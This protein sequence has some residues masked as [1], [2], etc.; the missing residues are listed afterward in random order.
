[1]D[2]KINIESPDQIEAF[3]NQEEAMLKGMV[4]KI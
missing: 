4:D 1:M 3:L 2:A